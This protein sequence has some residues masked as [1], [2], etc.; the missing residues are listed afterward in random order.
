M[1]TATHS[2]SDRIAHK[3]PLYRIDLGCGRQKR[4]PGAIGIDIRDYEPVDIVADIETGIPLPD[5]SVERVTAVSVLEHI[6]DLPGVMAEIH[7][8]C[9]DG[10]T[11]T[12]K[13]PHWRDRTAYSDPTH[14][15]RGV[16]G[17]GTGSGYPDCPRGACGFTTDTFDFWDPATE[18]GQ[19]GYFD[20]EFR[21]LWCHRIRRILIWKSRP[22]RFGLR[23]VK[24]DGSE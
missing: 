6:D 1:T 2:N 5:N 10:A 9:I 4:D 16:V 15:A 14:V 24:G 12:G 18:H 19:R 13:V 3:D 8:V 20:A 22:I 23:V 11:V 17:R 7:R 21:V